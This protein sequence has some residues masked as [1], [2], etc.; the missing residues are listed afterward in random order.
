MPCSRT[1]T[2][3]TPNDLAIA[4][5]TMSLNGVLVTRNSVDFQRISGL[6][7]EDW[8]TRVPCIE[9]LFSHGAWA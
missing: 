5:I 4:A 6:V 2:T 9:P 3:F 1:S 8:V 7:L